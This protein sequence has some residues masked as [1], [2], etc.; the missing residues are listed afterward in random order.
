MVQFPSTLQSQELWVVVCRECTG[1]VLWHDVW[2]AMPCYMSER[3]HLVWFRAAHVRRDRQVEWHPHEVHSGIVWQ[4]GKPEIRQPCLHWIHIPETVQL[5]M[6]QGV[7]N[8]RLAFT[9]MRCRWQ[10]DRRGCE[11]Q[12]RVLSGPQQPGSWPCHLP[13]NNLHEAMLCSLQKGLQSTWFSDQE[14]QRE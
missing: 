12:N 10:V 11:L 7:S 9:Q 13:W 8:V 6:S 1:Q 14:M 3:L 5:R 4:T 2:E